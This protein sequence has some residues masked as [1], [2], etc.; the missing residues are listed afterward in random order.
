MRG[1]YF[2]LDMLHAIETLFFGFLFYASEKSGSYCD[3][4]IKIK[5][6]FF[7]LILFL[8]Y[9]IFQNTDINNV[10]S[11]LKTVKLYTKI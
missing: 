11:F 10:I 5:N 8:L 2:G 7:K 4:K 9:L 6:L 3:E 1:H